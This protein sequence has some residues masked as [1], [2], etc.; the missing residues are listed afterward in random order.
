[1]QVRSQPCCRPE[2]RIYGFRLDAAAVTS[3]ASESFAEI[4]IHSSSPT[5]FTLASH[6]CCPRHWDSNR[7]MF[8][9]RGPG[10]LCG[11]R[12]AQARRLLAVRWFSTAK[13]YDPLRILF[14]GADEFSIASLKA[15]HGEHLRRPDR[16]A[17]IDVVCRPGKRVGRGLKNIREGRELSRLLLYF[18]LLF[19]RFPNID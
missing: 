14:C 9:L 12:H 13:S 16:I 1:M 4:R 10:T 3:R 2:H 17:S 7:T 11:Y 15:L 6:I 19:N 5:D 8:V 18:F